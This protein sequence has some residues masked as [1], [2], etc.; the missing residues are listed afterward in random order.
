ML[1]SNLILSA[2]LILFVSGNVP[3]G[4]VLLDAKAEINARGY[5]ITMHA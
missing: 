5:V 1:P 4:R 2:M 3:N